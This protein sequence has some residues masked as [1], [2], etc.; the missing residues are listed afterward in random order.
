M[1]YWLLI[2]GLLL[3]YKLGGG[4]LLGALLGLFIWH[5]FVSAVAARTVEQPPI[6]LKV[7]FATLGHLSKAKG[8]VMQRDIQFANS[9]MDRLHLNQ[10]ARAAAQQAFQYG[11]RADFH[12]RALLQEF[13][14]TQ[15]N[16][17]DLIRLFVKI[18]L[19][20]AFASGTPQ[21][22]ERTVVTMI[23]D[24]LAISPQQLRRL[25]ALLAGH[26]AFNS[27]DFD[28]DYSRDDLERHFYRYWRAR[29]HS[30]YY[31]QHGSQRYQEQPTAAQTLTLDS[32]CQ[33]L[34]VNNSD[35]HATIKRA[36]RKLMIRH[37]PD[38][39]M[40]KGLSSASMEQAKQQ[41]QK[42]QAAYDCIKRAKNF[43]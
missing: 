9:V 17:P 32:A 20:A 4:A 34:G 35:D 5:R 40:A 41:A 21:P 39:L 29:P 15:A 43:K 37:H 28:Y 10:A 25:F 33:V 2:C 3:G 6:F 8:Q 13:R 23:M 12:L 31:S 7:T 26:G 19:Q 11:K 36:Y 1:Q 16:R 14:A 38:K 42:I 18:Q 30:Q 24:E 22:S 27:S